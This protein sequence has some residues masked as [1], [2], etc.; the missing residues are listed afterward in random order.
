[1]S[2]A[3]SLDIPV[4]D[5]PSGGRI[6]DAMLQAQRACALRVAIAGEDGMPVARAR[7]GAVS[8]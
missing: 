5:T 8:A 4:Y 1:M 7:S 2:S 6:D 3:N